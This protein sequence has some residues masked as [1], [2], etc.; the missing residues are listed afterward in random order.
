MSSKTRLERF[1]LWFRGRNCPILTQT[2]STWD[3]HNMSERAFHRRSDRH[4]Q[5]RADDKRDFLIRLEEIGVWGD[6]KFNEEFI[7]LDFQP[8]AAQQVVERAAIVP[9]N[10]DVELVFIYEHHVML[11]QFDETRMLYLQ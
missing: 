10:N 5:T 4:T 7:Q 2:G 3:L 9:T 1:D 11:D 6:L 8:V